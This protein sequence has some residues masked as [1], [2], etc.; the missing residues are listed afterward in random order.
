[1]AVVAFRGSHKAGLTQA[2]LGA[3]EDDDLISEGAKKMKVTVA[4]ARRL[5][6][7]EMTEFQ[8][9]PSASAR[10]RLFQRARE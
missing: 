7:H 6:L 4:E 3:I 9:N 10:E 8:H 2:Q 1:M 5:Y